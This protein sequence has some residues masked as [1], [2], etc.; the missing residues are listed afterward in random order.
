MGTLKRWAGEKFP[1]KNRALPKAVTIPA[2]GR[3]NKVTK[4]QKFLH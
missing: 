2:S 4:K 3:Y 1:A